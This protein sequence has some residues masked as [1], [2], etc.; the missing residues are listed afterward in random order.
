MLRPVVYRRGVGRDLARAYQWY[1]ARQDGLGER[2]LSAVEQAS[3][4]IER[5]PEMFSTISGDVRRVLISGYPYAAFYRVESRRIV[6]L[7]VLHT[8]RNPAL[9]P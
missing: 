7:A 8:A 9:W 4:V 2:F 1:Q 6:V 5:F 3:G